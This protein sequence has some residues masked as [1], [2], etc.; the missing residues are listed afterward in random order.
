MPAARSSTS[1]TT[2]SSLDAR[3]TEPDFR[4][5]PELPRRPTTDACPCRHPHGAGGPRRRLLTPTAAPKPDPNSFRTWLLFYF[6]SKDLIVFSSG[7]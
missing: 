2:W 1:A 5:H 7:T 3:R 6:L 4:R